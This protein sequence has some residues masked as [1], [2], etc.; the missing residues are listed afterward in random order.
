MSTS[1]CTKRTPQAW[2]KP[3]L[4][5]AK[6]SCSMSVALGMTNTGVFA[7]EAI[8]AVT[9][10]LKVRAAGVTV[11][12]GRKPTKMEADGVDTPPPGK[13]NV[14]FSVKSLRVVDVF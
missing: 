5:C 6:P 7:Y 1:R 9:L 14:T 11:G 2:F 10:E 8:G 4:V 3:V 13:E 12:L